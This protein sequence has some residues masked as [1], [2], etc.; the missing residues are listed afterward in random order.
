VTENLTHSF[1]FQNL[2]GIHSYK[3][4]DE[5]PTEKYR[6]LKKTGL[7]LLS[8]EWSDLAYVYYFT[9]SLKAGRRPN[10]KIAS[11]HLPCSMTL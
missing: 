1:K 8:L 7:T 3:Y 2:E 5:I 9:F 4:Q 11:Y 10:D 6:V